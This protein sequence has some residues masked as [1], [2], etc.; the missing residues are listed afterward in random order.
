MKK[1][2]SNSR[3]GFTLVEV[4]V[5][6]VIVAIL[7]AVAIPMYLGYVNDTKQN[8]ANNE[9]A[10]FASAVSSAINYGFSGTVTNGTSSPINGPKLLTWNMS[11]FTPALTKDIT[12]MV[13]NGVSI[14]VTN[15]NGSPG[16]A[17][18]TIGGKTANVN[19]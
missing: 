19:W 12:Y 8:M 9:A 13:G 6:A 4:I 15:I 11:N 5:V 14:A 7:S 18:V 16:N 10:G 3:E 17:T 2:F 1:T